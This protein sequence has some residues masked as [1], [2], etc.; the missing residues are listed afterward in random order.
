MRPRCAFAVA[1]T[2][3]SAACTVVPERTDLSPR[4]PDGFK[5]SGVAPAPAEWWRAFDDAQLSELIAE[6]LAANLDLRAIDARLRAAQ[7]SAAAAGAPLAPSLDL[8]GS[9]TSSFGEQSTADL[10][11]VGLSASYEIDLW[12]RVRSARESAVLQWQA[13]EQELQAARI[14]LSANVAVIWFQIGS[15]AE[16]LRLIDQ[17]R[18][19][20]ARILHLVEAR[21]RN[22][23]APVTDVLR[24]RQLLESTR[25]LQATTEADLGR[26][27]HA[28]E[29][30]LGQAAGSRDITG[31]QPLALPPLPATGVPAKTVARRPDVQQAWLQVRAADSAVAAAIANRFP[32]MNLTASYVSNDAGTANLFDNWLGAL[33]GA[34]TV[35]LIDG[36]A[37]RAE[38]ERTRAVLDQRIIEY[39]RTVLAA[40]REVQDA[41]LQDRQLR[42]SVN[43]LDEQLRLSD[44]VVDRLE[45][46]LRNGSS[47]YL[48]L[49]DAQIANSSLRRERLSARQS[50][51]EQR[52]ALFRFLAGP[53]PTTD[54]QLS[55]PQ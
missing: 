7:A 50:L 4:L 29:E 5:R 28:L 21:F 42:V 26:L 18:A 41:L 38:V 33:V 51:A 17:E 19:T 27:R 35:P 1:V 6:A 2:L 52:I 53:L 36:G 24:Q 40:F 20:Y 49:L 31:R 34:V 46:Q 44:T 3:M 47:T 37:R 11:S 54:S 15:S 45:R 43:S 32:Q 16:R 39:R 12:G 23:Q 14:T 9:H 8:N 48:S 25:S 55:E 30:L 10:N 13:T 22:G